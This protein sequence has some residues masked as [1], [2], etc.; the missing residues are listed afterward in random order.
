[1]RT[2][3]EIRLSDLAEKLNLKLVGDGDILVRGVG[4]PEEGRAD[5]LHVIW[6][7]KSLKLAGMDVPILG[8]PEFFS[9]GRSGLASGDPRGTL[10]SLLA[11]FDPPRPAL[12]GVHPS[13]VVAAD[14][15]VADDARVGPCCVV[16]PGAVIE[17]GACLV[18][19]VYV[20]HDVRV[21]ERTVVEPHVA[22]MRGTCVGADCILHAGCVLGCDGFGFL[23]SETGLVKIPQVGDVVVE[24]DVEIGAG[25]TIDRGTVGDTVIGCGTKIDNH[26]QIGHNVKIGRHCIIC[27]MSGV[28]GSSVVEDWVTISAQVGVTDHVRIGR[29]AL[30][31][32]RAGV[33]NDVPEGAVLSGFPARPHKEARRALV[34]SARLPELYERVRQLERATERK[35]N[36]KENT[37]EKERQCSGES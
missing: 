36:T 30:L 11:V 37:K 32:G 33:T 19:D 1:M 14:A 12:R 15:R 6:D 8:R 3:V 16:E 4:A 9:E 26:V 29:G 35:E 27:S 7:E 23:R 10:P 28:A 2:D 22:L 13:A 31:G 5:V 24:D 18:A 17:A 25:T 20:G 21:G 34:L